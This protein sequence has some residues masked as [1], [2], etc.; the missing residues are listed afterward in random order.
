VRRVDAGGGAVEAP[1]RCV[2]GGA[3]TDGI[4]GGAPLGLAPPSADRSGARM[5]PDEWVRPW[6]RR[7]REMLGRIGNIADTR[8]SSA[9]T[10]RPARHT[11]S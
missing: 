2:V 4:A 9:A 5:L 6:W 7:A 10:K 8:G 11:S 1:L 3:G